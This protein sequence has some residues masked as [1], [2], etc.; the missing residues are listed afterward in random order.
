MP[1]RLQEIAEKNARTKL[2][3]LRL[4]RELE[5]AG[6]ESAAVFTVHHTTFTPINGWF[7]VSFR[8]RMLW[9]KACDVI[10]V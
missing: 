1:H 10:R 2:A 8:G 4:L 5:E 3:K 7:H 9:V 6:Q